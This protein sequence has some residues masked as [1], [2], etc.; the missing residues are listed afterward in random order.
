MLKIRLM[1]TKD[2]ITWFE[3]ILKRSPEVDVEELSD[4]Y[5]MKGTKKFFR[6]YA[7]VKHCTTE[8][9]Q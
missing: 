2:D 7:E 8:N 3:R 5:P 1:G 4:A 6:A 9:K